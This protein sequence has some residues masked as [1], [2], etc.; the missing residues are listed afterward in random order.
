MQKEEKI[1]IILNLSPCQLKFY[2]N[3]VY[4]FLFLKYY[5]TIILAYASYM[6]NILHKRCIKC[7]DYLDGTHIKIKSNFYLLFVYFTLLYLVFFFFCKVIAD[8]SSGGL[9]GITKTLQ[10]LVTIRSKLA[11]LDH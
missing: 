11:A 10:S 3:C 9:K 8:R 6:R 7:I 5:T 4:I 2:Y 1:T